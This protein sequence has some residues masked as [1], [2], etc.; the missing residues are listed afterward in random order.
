M[1][2][3]RGYPSPLALTS[4][5]QF[6]ELIFMFSMPWFVARLGLKRVVALGMLAWGAALSV[7][8]LSGFLRRP[9]RPG[10]ARI[11]LQLLLC[12]LRTCTSTSGRRRN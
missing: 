3:Q 11:L 1:L 7:F 12:R 6:S 8:R 9:D 4:L 5:N 10:L 2:Q